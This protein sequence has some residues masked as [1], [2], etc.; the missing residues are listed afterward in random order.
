M[1]YI[2]IDSVQSFEFRNVFE[3]YRKFDIREI[4]HYRVMRVR[5]FFIHM[6]FSRI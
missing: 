4:Q 3:R 5:R 2:L 1:R 6:T